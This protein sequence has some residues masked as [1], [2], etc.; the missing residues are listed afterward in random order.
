MALREESWAPGVGIGDVVECRVEK[1]AIFG[2]FV[3]VDEKID[4]IVERIQMEQVG[5]DTPRDYPP[6]GSV[7]K[8]RVLG[9]RDWSHQVEIGLFPK[10]HT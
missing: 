9:F 7:I 2:V 10:T 8:G 1:H 6:V 3:S 5:Y 4:G